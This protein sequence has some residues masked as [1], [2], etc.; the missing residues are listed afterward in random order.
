MLYNSSG[1]HNHS[2]VAYLTFNIEGA[3]TKRHRR[4]LLSG[5]QIEDDSVNAWSIPV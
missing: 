5:N 2:T 4:L 3:E 1:L